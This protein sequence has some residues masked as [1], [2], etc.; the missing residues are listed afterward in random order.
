MKFTINRSKIEYEIIKR[1]EEIYDPFDPKTEYE[2]IFNLT[3]RGNILRFYLLFYLDNSGKILFENNF[4]DCK[5]NT[6]DVE[7]KVISRNPNPSSNTLQEK[8]DLFLK[9]QERIKTE[10][11]K[12]SKDWNETKEIL[13]QKMR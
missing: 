7:L 6:K 5:C 10:S 4:I 2:C 8:V 1:L 12:D 3:K 11:I 9:D 13:N